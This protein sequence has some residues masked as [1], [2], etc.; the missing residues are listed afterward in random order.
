MF[1]T[2]KNRNLE[3]LNSLKKE[4]FAEDELTL[5]FSEE[6]IINMGKKITKLGQFKIVEIGFINGIHDVFVAVDGNSFVISGFFD[7]YKD[8]CFF[9]SNIFPKNLN[10]IYSLES[11]NIQKRMGKETI[12]DKEINKPFNPKNVKTNKPFWC[13]YL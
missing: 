5:L 6:E 3:I 1:K 9:L 10:S 13:G 7:F 4:I 11:L 2:F 12:F 8:E